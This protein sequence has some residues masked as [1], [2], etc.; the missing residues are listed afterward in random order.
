MT[1]DVLMLHLVILTRNGSQPQCT[2][3]A[4]PI[5]LLQGDHHH[6]GSHCCL[7]LPLVSTAF[8]SQ[9][10]GAVVTTS[11]V[12]LRLL[13]DSC[14]SFVLPQ[15]SCEIPELGQLRNVCSCL[16]IRILQ[17]GCSNTDSASDIEI[18]ASY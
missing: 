14:M 12:W 17:T 3:A 18:R 16:G 11:A 15:L 8:P 4:F 5:L 13:G 9:E 2:K 1:F 6:A 7:L 10:L